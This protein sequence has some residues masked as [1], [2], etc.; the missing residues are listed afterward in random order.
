MTWSLKR[1]LFLKESSDIAIG[2]PAFG[3]SVLDGAVWH[4][5]RATAIAPIQYRME[6]DRY[7]NDALSDLLVNKKELNKYIVVKGEIIQLA[8]PI[9]LDPQQPMIRAHFFAPR[10]KLFG[11]YYDTFWV[12]LLVIWMMSLVLVITLYFNLFRKFI[13]ST[14]DLFSK[15]SFSRVGSN[16]STP[17]E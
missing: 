11:T 5:T 12:N 1:W 7:T 14:G 10:K 13:D 2:S 16:N 17:P 4:A 15:L 9:Y 6:K 3:A 8:D